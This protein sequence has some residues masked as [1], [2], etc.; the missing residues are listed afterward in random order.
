MHG[1]FRVHLVFELLM[2]SFPTEV[3]LVPFYDSRMCNHSVC[4]EVKV[5]QAHS[6]DGAGVGIPRWIE[7]ENLKRVKR[8]RSRKA[9]VCLTLLECTSEINPYT[10]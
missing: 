3:L 5:R 6:K 7:I 8:R 2:F 1:F 10:V 9:D 4:A